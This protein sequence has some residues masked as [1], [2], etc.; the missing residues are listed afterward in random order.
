M[1]SDR[2]KGARVIPG[3]DPD[4]VRLAAIQGG[5][6]GAGGTGITQD[7]PYLI[8]ANGDSSAHTFTFS[9]RGQP[10]GQFPYTVAAGNTSSVPTLPFSGV[11]IDTATTSVGWAFSDVPIN[12]STA[13]GSGIGAA[14]VTVG[15]GNIF[16]YNVAGY[17]GDW[18]L[19][20]NAAGAALKAAKGG[21]VY[22]T[23]GIGTT[24]V[25]STQ[26]VFWN[27][28]NYIGDGI[29]L[30]AAASLSNPFITDTATPYQSGL[31]TGLTLDGN[32]VAGTTVLTLQTTQWCTFYDLVV[33]GASAGSTAQTPA[34]TGAY[35]YTN[36]S[37]TLAQEV[38][39]TVIAGGD[40]I[41]APVVN[42]NAVTNPSAGV[43]TT[44][45][46]YPSGTL[47]TTI[48]GAGSNA[49]PTV[50]Q[51]AVGIL[52]ITNPALSVAGFGGSVSGSC[53]F[54]SVHVVAG[55]VGWV[56]SGDS[57]TPKQC[58]NHQF[59]GC[60]AP[61]TTVAGVVIA[62]NADSNVFIRTLSGVNASNGVGYIFNN[63]N[64]LNDQAVYYNTF[65][66]NTSVDCPG[67]LT[68]TIGILVGKNT[69]KPNLIYNYQPSANINTPVA[70]LLTAFG[71][72][73]YY[74][75]DRVTNVQ[76]FGSEL[77]GT[78]GPAATGMT[79]G[80][81]YTN[82]SPFT[83]AIYIAGGLTSAGGITLNGTIILPTAQTIVNMTVILRPGDTLEIFAAVTFPTTVLTQ[84]ISAA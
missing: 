49:L 28:V 57:T 10:T 50:T 51:D 2:A 73:S 84:S 64:P 19:A 54:V 48:T 43:P 69:S 46:I 75:N 62:N 61:N 40:T 45:T 77:S 67:A 78:T 72:H 79:S 58:T 34:A 17:G 21:T 24:G 15:N 5:T 53:S 37:A 23:G 8:I 55:Q 83:Q 63:A 41:S 3:A 66:G 59:F 70:K 68:G 27:T 39:L 31:I 56:I 26:T 35:T 20:I 30:Q 60:Q 9:I 22:I 80:T 71:S 44:Y 81:P 33:Q 7:L 76:W 14:F 74:I 47:T 82:N 65:L 1:P 36:H 18:G 4:K 29:T 42:G 52:V 38:T 13:A 12:P 11:T 6:F 25:V 32:G 16:T